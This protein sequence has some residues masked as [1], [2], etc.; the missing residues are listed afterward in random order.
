MVD[1]IEL[2]TILPKETLPSPRFLEFYLPL[3]LRKI[4]SIVNLSSELDMV[5][6][7]KLGYI[8]RVLVHNFPKL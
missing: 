3:P 8:I 2:G 7:I 4:L 5:T 6:L 1:L